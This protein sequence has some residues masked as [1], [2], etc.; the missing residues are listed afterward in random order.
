MSRKEAVQLLELFAISLA[1]RL[2]Y[3]AHEAE[4]YGRDQSAHVLRH[5]SYALRAVPGSMTNGDRK[6]VSRRAD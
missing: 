2:E 3:E 6:E 4:C 5:F 1:D